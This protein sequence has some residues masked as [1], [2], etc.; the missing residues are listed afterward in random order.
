MTTTT[1]PKYRFRFA[2]PP[3]QKGDIVP[4]GVF[5]KGEMQTMIDFNRIE[6]VP[7][8]APK[9]HAPVNDPSLDGGKDKP[10]DAPKL[11]NRKAKP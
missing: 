8:V 5:G 3:Y 10:I 9:H 2:R 11:S 6:P 4:N 1:Q 7:D